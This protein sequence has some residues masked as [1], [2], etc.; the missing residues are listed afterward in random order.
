[1]KKL[2]LVLVLACILVAA[3]PMYLNLSL[4][5]GE[6][7]IYVDDSGSIRGVRSDGVWQLC[8]ANTCH[9]VQGGYCE[10]HSIL[11]GL[12]VNETAELPRMECLFQGSEN[13]IF[14]DSPTKRLANLTHLPLMLSVPNGGGGPAR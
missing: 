1:M 12:W 11:G 9:Y 4:E 14:I 7:V 13:Y 3:A 5:R 2:L 10:N 6:Q 8:I